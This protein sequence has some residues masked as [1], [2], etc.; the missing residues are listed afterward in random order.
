MVL[1]PT[2]SAIL[3]QLHVAVN[4]ATVASNGGAGIESVSK[5]KY[6]APKYFSTQDR[7]VTSN[8]Y[9]SIVRNIY[10]AISDIITFGGEEDDPKNTV[11]LRSSSNQKMLVSCLLLQRRVL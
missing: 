11:K 10:P 1:L 7:A 8:D 3:V 5:I 9:G 4:S 2:N 6:N